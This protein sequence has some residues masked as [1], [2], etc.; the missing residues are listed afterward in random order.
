MSEQQAPKITIEI[1]GQPYYANPGEMVIQVADRHGIYIP[2]FCY[3]KKLS[4]AAN[5]RMCLVEIEK[6][7]KPSPACA[8]P[9]MDGMKVFTKSPKTLS[10][11]KK[12]MEFLL[13][14]HPLDCPI[15]DQGGE[16]ELQDIS[17]GYGN[18]VSKYSE[19]KRAFD[20]PSLGPLVATDMTRCIQCTRCVRFG[21][22]IAG[23]KELGA[24]GRGDHVYISTYVKNTVDS[25][26]SGNIIDLCPVGA[27]TSKPFRF[28]ARAWELQQYPTISCADAVGAN[29]YAHVRR[30]QLMRLVPKDN[31]AINET[32]IADKD[33]FSYLGVHS[34]DRLQSPMIKKNGT[35]QTVSWEE[36][37]DFIKVAIEQ[38]KQQDGVQAISSIASESLP[39]EALFLLQ[40]LMRDIGTNN[41]DTRLKQ[42]GLEKGVYS[43]TGLDCSLTDIEQAD[44]I[45]LLG[46]YLRKEIPLINHRVRKAVKNNAQVIAIN[47]Q[48]YDF[49][50]PVENVLVE[51]SELVY[52]LSSL[53]KAVSQRV[54]KAP[55]SKDILKQFLADV[56]IAPAIE[57]I[58]AKLIEAKAPV[59]IA[60]FD[61]VL[62]KDFAQIY[63][64]IAVIKD[65]LGAKGGTL[66]FGANSKGAL[67]SGMTP[68]Y[69]PQLNT[70]QEVGKSAKEVFSGQTD[71]KLLL[72]AG[73]EPELDAIWGEKV[74]KALGKIDI[75][76]AFSA[77]D[78]EAMREYADIMLP[79]ATH[80]EDEGSFVNISG[81][82]QHFKAVISAVGDS[83]PLWKILRV[84]GNLLS[85]E[86]YEYQSV[87]EVFKQWHAIEKQ[88][89]HVDV[90]GL[91]SSSLPAI[92][93]KPGLMPI[94]SMYKT[95]ALLRRSSALQQTKDAKWYDCV[96]VSQSIA[97]AYAL[98][99][100][101]FIGFHIDGEDYILSFSIDKDIAQNTIAV[102]FQLMPAC[103]DSDTSVKIK[104]VK[105]EVTEQ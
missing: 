62:N 87:D 33:R 19:T 34:Q 47:S 4:V 30:N 100:A 52:A 101:E 36:A 57:E 29:V 91:L 88:E 70:A 104:P 3:H 95:D 72:L 48:Y 9:V 15:C 5:C 61:A 55:V 13:I 94:I 21:E 46:S 8:T 73:V 98:E 39:T 66:S 68:E 53:V 24:M 76:V 77:F 6:A 83:K 22:E 81:E 44:A 74:T 54:S 86:G 11:Q 75:V 25:E 92:T 42:G 40:K 103:I 51:T 67:L 89:N 32:W 65:L 16:C 84:L 1:D 23:D 10:Y 28:K 38:T 85:I 93:D 37:L 64:L 71:T 49:N 102:P 63:A 80:F 105:A 12:V 50:Y 56:D 82:I 14:N 45:L 59:V 27:L 17:M 78:N 69:T 90:E 58:A 7:R 60:G 79:I 35:W 99:E 26:L 41:I 31:E 18:D 97:S 2:R 96:R 43:S 20:D